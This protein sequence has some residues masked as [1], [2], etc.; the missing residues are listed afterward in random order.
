[1]VNFVSITVI[2]PVI[3]LNEHEDIWS[4]GVRVVTCGQRINR[5]LS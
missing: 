3:G 1:L 2:K 4:A 5:Y